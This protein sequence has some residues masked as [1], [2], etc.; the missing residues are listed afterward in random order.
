MKVITACNNFCAGISD[1]V[2]R[3]GSFVTGNASAQ[4]R[5]PSVNV[6][7]AQTERVLQW[8]GEIAN[9]LELASI[10]SLREM[11]GSNTQ[12]VLVDIELL[13]FLR[14]H[15]GDTTCT[16][17]SLQAH[18]EWKTTIRGTEEVARRKL[19]IHSPLQ[20][21]IFWLG[22]NKEDCATLVIRTQLHDGSYF[23]EDPA[24]FER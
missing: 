24:L 6:P 10:Q 22:V 16:L 12:H 19:V 21:E 4:T 5:A 8:G 17:A 13:R 7:A 18:V 15:R 23:N 11:I 20:E 2:S 9:A 1:V 14:H 3:L